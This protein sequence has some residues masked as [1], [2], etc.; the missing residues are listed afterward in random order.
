MGTKCLKRSVFVLPQ[1][2]HHMFLSKKKY[3]GISPNP[4]QEVTLLTGRCEPNRQ[5]SGDTAQGGEG[6]DQPVR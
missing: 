6:G 3:S 2:L 1:K 4:H 5:K